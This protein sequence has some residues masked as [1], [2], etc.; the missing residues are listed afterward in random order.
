[1]ET[2]DEEKRRFEIECEFVQ[3]LAN[4]NYLNFLAQRGYFKED[5]FVNY[6]QY[7][8]YWKKPEYARCLKFPQ[9]LFILEALQSPQFREAMAFPHNAKFVEDQLVL[10]WQYYLR[11]RS[12]LCANPEQQAKSEEDD[13]QEEHNMQQFKNVKSKTI[14]TEP[15]EPKETK[16]KR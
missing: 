2:Q 5:Y 6:L 7:L 9:C 10:Q 4:P 14:K 8:M 1:M 13:E 15:K 12:R 11:K 3:S 16:L